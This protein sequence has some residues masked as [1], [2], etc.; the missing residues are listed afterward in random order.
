[1]QSKHIRNTAE[2]LL[3]CKKVAIWLCY[4]AFS[5]NVNILRGVCIHLH[6]ISFCFQAGLKNL[7]QERQ[8][9]G[10]TIPELPGKKITQI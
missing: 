8:N 2:K 4:V 6:E 5:S 3:C 9:S 7:F 10:L 1:M